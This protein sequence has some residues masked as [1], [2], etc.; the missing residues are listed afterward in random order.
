MAALA[1]NL[2]E[3]FDRFLP[4]LRLEGG[5]TPDDVIAFREAAIAH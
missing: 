1:G 4:P 2:A 3:R 5:P